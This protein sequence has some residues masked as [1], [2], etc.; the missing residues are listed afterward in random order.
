[1]SMPPF[2]PARAGLALVIVAFS[3][4]PSMAQQRLELGASLAAVEAYDD[5][6]FFS[7]DAPERDEIWRLSPRLS[8]SRRSTRLTLRARYG[9]DAERYRRHPSL[10]TP[11]AGQDASLEMT[12]TPSRRVVASTT[13]SYAQS[14]SPGMLNVLTG[15]QLGRRRARRLFARQW[16]SWQIGERTSGTLEP[17]FTQ[18]E[19]AGLPRTDTEGVVVGLERR[20]GASDRARVSYTGRRFGFEGSAVFAHVFALG[21]SREITPLAHFEVEAGPRFSDRAVGAEVSA[22][23][24][25]HF[26][27]GEAVLAY[28]HTQTTVLGEAGPVITKGVTAAFRRQLS[29]ALTVAAGPTFARVQGRDSEFE[30]FRVNVDVDWRLTRRLSLSASHQFNFQSG[31]PGLTTRNAEIAHNAFVLRA[32]A[33]S[34]G[35]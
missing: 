11:L 6:L 26:A 4:N 29:E 28:V 25:H 18:E 10:D 16:L 24:R 9:L 35:H 30:V 22:R 8:L 7:S 33:S 1:M 23:L 14:Q 17:T 15:L 13:A 2:S 34:S 3:T 20:L 27:R 12:W 32:V 5:N 31:M 19:V 21:W